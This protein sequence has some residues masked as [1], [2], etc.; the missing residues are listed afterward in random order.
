MPDDQPGRRPLVSVITPSF[1]QGHYIAET[2]ESVLSQDYRDIEYLV[3]D[4]GSTDSTLDVLRG[5]GDRVAWTSERDEGQSDAIR[6]GF[7][8]ARG[9][10]IAWLNADDTY[11]A[12]A[13]RA[14]VEAFDE[15]PG[16]GLVYGRA[17]FI[18]AAGRPRGEH[19]VH[20]WDLEY[21][22]SQTNFIPQ[23]ATFFRRSA[24]DAIGGLDVDLHYVMDYD[25]WIRLGRHAGV[26]RIDRVMARI[27]LYPNTKTAGGGLVRIEELRRMIGRHGRRRLPEWL[28]WDLFR[29]RI[30]AGIALDRQHRRGD[31]LRMLLAAMP[32]IWH[33]MVMVSAARHIAWRAGIAYRDVPRP[34]S[35]SPDR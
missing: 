28:Y 21:L 33:P 25:L 31:A 23:P 1:N 16:L 17:Q 6:K 30:R 10:I 20:E 34:G 35:D 32:L 11:I 18:D 22:V 26:R 13:V 2:I 3:I 9:E 7:K 8:Q 14:A 27:R 15:D 29:E 5:Y 24:Y 12:G 4:G 19:P